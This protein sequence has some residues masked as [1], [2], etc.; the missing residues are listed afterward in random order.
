M[1]LD[2]MKQKRIEWAD[3]VKGLAI[4]LM[5]FCHAGCTHGNTELLK[6]IYIFHMPL[7]FFVSGY[8]DKARSFSVELLKKNFSQLLVPYFF[9]SACAFSVCW[10]N[11]Y[12]HPETY[13]TYTLF[14]AFWHGILGLFIMQD[15]ITPLSYMPYG[16][17]WFLPALFL[18]RVLFS[19]LCMIRNSIMGGVIL[20]VITCVTV[21]YCDVNL[22]SI[23]SAILALPIYASGF[24][25]KKYDLVER[26]DTNHCAWLFIIGLAYTLT[27]G[28]MN[29]KVSMNRAE[30]GDNLL[31]FYVNAII[32]TLTLI[33]Y[34]KAINLDGSK[35]SY[36]GSSTLSI[37]GIHLYAVIFCTTIAIKIF[38]YQTSNIPL[39]FSLLTMVIGVI[40]GLICNEVLLKYF[41]V[42]IGKSRR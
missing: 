24:L 13:N 41:P 20:I 8:F 6:F 28:M 12:L 27:L 40:S 32:A 31:M 34:F 10:I 30:Y 33:C 19:L 3:Q 4:I 2:I 1:N 23:K 42:A 37:L 29:S 38:H 9:F 21:F 25:F 22:F 15:N 5:V 18:V 39:W 35:L 16:P 14:A 11:P 26:V 7:F 17:L 36:I